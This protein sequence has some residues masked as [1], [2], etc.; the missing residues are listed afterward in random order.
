M[1]FAIDRIL[2]FL[3]ILLLVALFMGTHAID[4]EHSIVSRLHCS[5][6]GLLIFQ[7]NK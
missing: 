2:I 1:S 4:A 6:L 7:L 5:G 3:A